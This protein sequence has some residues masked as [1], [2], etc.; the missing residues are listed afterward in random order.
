M[1]T[2]LPYPDF[3]ASARVLDQARLGKQRVETLQVLR[4]LVIPDYGWRQH[5]AIR[6]WM[7]YVPALTVY[8]LAMV[9]E[10][11]SRGHADSTH[12]QIL[13][14][15]PEVLDTAAVPMPPWLGDPALHLSHRS[16]L[17]QKA[18]EVYR[19]RFPGVPE[20]LPYVW[21]EPE[22]ERIPA[23]PEGRRLWVWRAS[24]LPSDGDDAT[25]L[26]MPPDPPG[27]RAAPKWERQL[28]VF[29]ETVQDGDAVAIADPGG[30]HFRA[31][32]LGPVLMHE[33]GLVRRARLH[34]CVR[35]SDIHPSALLQ[36]PR[37]LFSV[38]LPESLA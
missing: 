29:E 15:A 18:P 35:R 19:D 38:G 32:Q 12:R 17:V 23:E 3:E 7:G 11:V 24:A 20:D 34:G 5:P 33:D 4:A 13:E 28:R 8:G 2:F 26:L 9:S 10:W 21:P 30:E 37:T 36:D 31:G 6:M 25:T 1:Q 16:N 27:G 22:E 14:F